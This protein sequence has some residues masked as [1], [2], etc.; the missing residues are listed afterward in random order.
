LANLQQ[1]TLTV[2]ELT[3]SGTMLYPADGYEAIESVTFSGLW[4]YWYNDCEY[5]T[6]NGTDHGALHL[7]SNYFVYAYPEI[8]ENWSESEDEIF[9]DPTTFN[10]VLASKNDSHSSSRCGLFSFLSEESYWYDYDTGNEYQIPPM[11]WRLVEASR[12]TPTPFI[13]VFNETTLT[14]ADLQGGVVLKFLGTSHLNSSNCGSRGSYYAYFVN[15]PN[16][17][18]YFYLLGL[19][20]TAHNRLDPNLGDYVDLNQPNVINTINAGQWWMSAAYEPIL[21]IKYLDQEITY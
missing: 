6:V 16:D 17:P 20:L 13:R 2:D 14:A 10:P 18:S 3:Q 4:D 7:Y 21:F 12:F 5:I 8:V 9:L 19:E 1:I 11:R 15:S